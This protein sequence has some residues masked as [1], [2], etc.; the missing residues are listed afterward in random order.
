MSVPF[1]NTHLRVPRGFGNILEGLAREVLRDQPKDIPTFAALYFTALLKERE[2]SGLDPAEWCA[3]L[4]DRFYNNHAFKN[5]PN[6]VD[7]SPVDATLKISKKKDEL[8]E[9]QTEEE[10]GNIEPVGIPSPTNSNLDVYEDVQG[11]ESQGKYEMVNITDKDV[12]SMQ[13]YPSE[14]S[15]NKLTD[16]DVNM[17]GKE[18]NER[19]D[20][21]VCL[22]EFEPSE[23][24]SLG[25]LSNVD[26]C[27]EELRKT[28]EGE[29]LTSQEISTGDDA[30]LGSSYE[31]NR[32][33]EF[34][35]TQEVSFTGLFNIDV[36]AEELRGTKEREEQATAEDGLSEGF[37][38]QDLADAQESSISL[39]V[40]NSGRLSPLQTESPEPILQETTDNSG[41]VAEEENLIVST[42]YTGQTHEVASSID[43][44]SRILS[45]NESVLGD[46]EK[47]KE[48]SI[49]QISTEE[50]PKTLK[51][52][53]YEQQPEEEG[54]VEASQTEAE[55]PD[56]VSEDA[57]EETGLVGHDTQDSVEPNT[58]IEG[59]AE[60]VTAEAEAQI[61]AMEHEASDIEVEQDYKS[62][63]S[64][65]DGEKFS[66][67]NV[68]IPN[69]QASQIEQKQEDEPDQEN[70]NLS[71]KEMGEDISPEDSTKMENKQENDN[72]YINDDDIDM[73][74][75]YISHAYQQG[76]SN[77][78]RPA[79]LQQEDAEKET[80]DTAEQQED[81]DAVEHME[82]ELKGLGKEDTMTPSQDTDQTDDNPEHMP[83]GE[84]KDSVDKT[85]DKEEC[86]Q[87]QEEE[88]IMDIPLDDPEAN[89]AAAKIQAG[90]RGHM[91]RKKIKPADKP[92]GEE[93][94][95][96]NQA[97]QTE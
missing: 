28:E 91:T 85:Y 40:E 7:T 46:D 19:A 34:E 67:V 43:D 79:E 1:S 5:S 2:D 82:T 59:E 42:T 88:D 21:M 87:P 14:V 60:A 75:K 22:S 29:E 64:D 13:I 44:A 77:E 86:S 74:G 89:K 47:Q 35:L 62:D 4:E 38:D 6:Q 76:P 37:K 15:D 95:E 52:K 92:E 10:T 55:R 25:G 69:Q 94:D 27:A 66:K 39:M 83:E 58:N 24:I 17:T 45:D 61:K 72:P 16:M 12:I 48:E 50:V 73:G 56:V 9:S 65:E 57:E 93:E 96:E 84:I 31:M 20:K 71:K 3:R 49:V 97:A 54:S 51:V 18:M 41:G 68:R 90:F 23:E 26:V 36:C 11:T 33:S 8:T 53:M 70:K 81:I 78:V 80:G 32:S 63:S 30:I